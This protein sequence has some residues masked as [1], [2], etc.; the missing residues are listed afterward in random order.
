MSEETNLEKLAKSIVENDRKNIMRITLKQSRK[1]RHPAK[2]RVF[3]VLHQQIVKPDNKPIE[4]LSY[5]G[6]Y[7]IDPSNFEFMT[8]LQRAIKND[9][10]DELQFLANQ[11]FTELLFLENR[12]YWTRTVSLLLEHVLKL[13]HISIE[14]PSQDAQRSLLHSSTQENEEEDD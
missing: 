3:E 10:K 4:V 5:A 8:K 7:L 1:L 2:R 12:Y 9:N 11:Y 14:K 13:K 6:K